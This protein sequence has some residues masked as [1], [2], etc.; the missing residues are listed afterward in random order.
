MTCRMNT[1]YSST[2]DCN[3]RTIINND[4]NVTVFM[5]GFQKF[6]DIRFHIATDSGSHGGGTLKDAYIKESFPFYP[7]IQDPQGNPITLQANSTL[8]ES[9]VPCIKRIY[10]MSE[11]DPNKINVDGSKGMFVDRVPGEWIYDEACK[12]VSESKGNL[13]DDRMDIGNG[14]IV[15]GIQEQANIKAL[16]QS[17]T[18]SQALISICPDIIPPGNT[19]ACIENSIAMYPTWQLYDIYTACMVDYLKQNGSGNGGNG[20]GNGVLPKSN[21]WL[22]V[23]AGVGLL[24]LLSRGRNSES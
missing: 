24:L 2:A 21:T 17:T 16:M 23:I 13:K 5:P 12:C 7:T 9:I 10:Q 22:Y 20:S 19:L 6:M 1:F 8:R 3:V 4:N 11:W 15:P 14:F 18:F